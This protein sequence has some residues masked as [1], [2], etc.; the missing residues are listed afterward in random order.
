MIKQPNAWS[1]LPAAFAMA[2]DLPFE[3]VIAEIGH[4]GSEIIWPEATDPFNRRSFHIQELIYVAFNNWHSVTSFEAYPISVRPGTA[5][6]YKLEGFEKRLFELMSKERGV[7]TGRL[8]TGIRHAMYWEFDRVYDPSKLNIDK[9]D[10]RFMVQTFWCV[11]D[12]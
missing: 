6:P 11:Q 2:I 8:H 1:C 5:V 3:Q 12:D 4:D 7:V 9:L 10:D